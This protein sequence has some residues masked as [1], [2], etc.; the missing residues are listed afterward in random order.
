MAC[1]MPAL[2]SRKIGA[3]VFLAATAAEA[4][5]IGEIGPHRCTPGVVTETLISDYDPLVLQS[6]DQVARIVA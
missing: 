3:E 6:P 1:T 5:A 4:V 2:S